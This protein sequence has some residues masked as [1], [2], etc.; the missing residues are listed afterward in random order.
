MLTNTYIVVT[1]LTVIGVGWTA[2]TFVL[3]AVLLRAVFPGGRPHPPARRRRAR[4]GRPV[5]AGSH[6][7]GVAPA[8]GATA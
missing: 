8:R 1:A 5:R 7:A 6:P 2:S 4:H 3:L